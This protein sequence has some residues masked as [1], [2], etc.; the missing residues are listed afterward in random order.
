[1]LVVMRRPF[2]LVD[3]SIILALA[4]IAVVG[5]KYSPLLLAKADLTVE[6]AAACDLHKQACHADIP[7]GGRIEL[8]L[9]PHPIPV[10]KPL[11]V[12]A[13]LSGITADSVEIDF[14]GVDM[15]MGL[16]RKTLVA[17]GDGRY[18]AEAMIPVCMTGRMAWRA[19]LVVET[20]RQR[21]AV[22]FLFEAPI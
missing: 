1:M 7:G 18:T 9:T 17:A 4:I 10:V 8:S 20:G 15:N 11:Q 14:A 22:P 13:T 6:P 21:I 3:L 2:S 5:Y 19:T 12:S 16:N